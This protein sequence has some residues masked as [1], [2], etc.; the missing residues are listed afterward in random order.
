MGVSKTLTTNA[1]LCTMNLLNGPV[2]LASLYKTTEKNASSP[3]NGLSPIPTAVGYD[4]SN[5]M[6]PQRSY[7]MRT[8]GMNSNTL[9]FNFS[10]DISVNMDGVY[11][12]SR[13]F[14]PTVFAVVGSNITKTSGNGFTLEGDSTA[15]FSS[16]VVYQNLQLY[17][18]RDILLWYL[19]TPT[20][21]TAGSK[22][23]WRIS[24]TPDTT[25]TNDDY[26]EISSFFLGCHYGF[27]M[28]YGSNRAL[29]FYSKQGQSGSGS[30][31]Y[32]E[33]TTTRKFSI[34]STLLDKTTR[35]LLLND[36]RLGRHN[37]EC[38][39]DTAA[40][41]SDSSSSRGRGLAYGYLGSSVKRSMNIDQYQKIDIDLVESP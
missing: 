35:R 22:A 36:I 20:S 27:D 37:T 25:W 10:I 18:Q 6:L 32:A 7:K 29:E 17:E 14:T 26:I 24:C 34:D 13:T 41:T 31:F 30:R 4:T 39:V 33:K 21:G 1:S 19:D 40:S 8:A 23:Y 15:A 38:I 9:Y 12:A 3:S 28:D 5:L 16:P 2:G 11:S